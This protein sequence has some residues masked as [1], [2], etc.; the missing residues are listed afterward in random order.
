MA[1][2]IFLLAYG[3]YMLLGKPRAIRLQHP[4]LDVLSGFLGGITG[5]A[6]GF[7]SAAVTI[8][9]S[10]RGWDKA[11]QRALFQP[12]ILIMQ[13]AALLAIS[14]AQGHTMHTVGLDPGTLLCI[15]GGLLGTQLGMS[16]YQ[17]LSNRQFATAV[18]LLLLVSGLS[19]LL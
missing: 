12:F 9:C 8:L 11:R 5:G 17:R 2:G 19:F 7:P 14:L 6:V 10:L 1:F 15:P 3:L 16:L 13:V 4:A 18:N